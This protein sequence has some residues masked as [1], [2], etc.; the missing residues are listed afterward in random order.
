MCPFDLLPICK[1]KC[2]NFKGII[3]KTISI[4]K[5]QINPDKCEHL[6]ILTCLGK[7]TVLN[8]TNLRLTETLTLC[9]KGRLCV[10]AQNYHLAPGAPSKYIDLLV[11]VIGHLGGTNIFAV[12]SFLTVSRNI[13]YLE[14]CY[15]TIFIGWDKTT[16]I[17]FRGS[18]L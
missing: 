7:N 13:K 11:I 14:I 9:A 4:T 2:E 15:E 3:Y 1:K 17:I 10:L 6:F 8:L 18:I 12:N 16:G 5:M